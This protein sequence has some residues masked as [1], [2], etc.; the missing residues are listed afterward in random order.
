M[1]HDTQLQ[2]LYTDDETKTLMPSS[3]TVIGLRTDLT[4]AQAATVNQLRQAFAV[5]RMYEK[6]ARGGRA[7]ACASSIKKSRK[8][9]GR[10]NQKAS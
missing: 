8:K 3:K 2:T 1:N 10:L 6:D 7:K 9:T 4:A 5:Q